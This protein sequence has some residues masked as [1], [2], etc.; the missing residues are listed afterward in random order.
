M[1]VVVV[2]P[3]ERVTATSCAD[4]G[5]DGLALYESD[6]H[7]ENGVG[8][9]GCANDRVHVMPG[10]SVVPFGGPEGAKAYRLGRS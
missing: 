4:A 3:F 2:Q 1:A 9:L 6:C 7:S 5:A 8:R 10:V